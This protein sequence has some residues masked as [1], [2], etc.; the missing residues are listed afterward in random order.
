MNKVLLVTGGSRGIGRAVAEMAASAGAQVMDVAGALSAAVCACAGTATAIEL[1]T[2]A[3]ARPVTQ[4]F[5]GDNA[6]FVEADLERLAPGR[7]RT[8]RA[9][10]GPMRPLV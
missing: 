9:L 4:R 8:P 6:R 5:P 7:A 10:P 2:T 1:N 3:T